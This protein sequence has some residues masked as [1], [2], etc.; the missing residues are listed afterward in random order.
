MRVRKASLQLVARPA[1]TPFVEVL[2]ADPPWKFG[3]AIQGERGASHKYPCM[4]VDQ[5]ARFEIPDMAERSILFMW[6]VAAMQEEA[7]FVCK[8]W[9]FRPYSEIVWHKTTKTGKTH[10]GMGHVVRASHEC[11][12]IGVRGRRLPPATLAER[13][14]ITGLVRKHSEKP[15]EFYTLIER[16]YPDAL[17]HELFAR[18]VRDGWTQGGNQLGSITDDPTV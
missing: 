5:I 13:S 16:L 6:R 1:F 15:E 8:A 4:P 2:V 10:F 11:C 9:G 14:I 3:D 18:R 17:K 12:L 7:L